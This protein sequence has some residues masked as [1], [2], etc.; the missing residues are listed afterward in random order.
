MG[1]R[2]A[3]DGRVQIHSGPCVQTNDSRHQKAAF[4][5]EVMLIR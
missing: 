5:N 2:K 1:Q 3:L 4:D